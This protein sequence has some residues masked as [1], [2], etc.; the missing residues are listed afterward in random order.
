M[1]TTNQILFAIISFIVFVIAMVVLY[2]KDSAIN[3]KYYKG[4]KWVLLGFIV[5]IALLIFLKVSL[6]AYN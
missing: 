4:S 2:K 3:N 6:K 1:F 5:F